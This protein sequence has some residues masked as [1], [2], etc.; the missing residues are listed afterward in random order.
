MC[1]YL[2]ECLGEYHSIANLGMDQNSKLK[3]RFPLNS[4]CYF[5]Q[6]EIV[7]SKVS[8]IIK[9][10]AIAHCGPWVPKGTHFQYPFMDLTICAF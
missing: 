8:P 6:C 7:A 10:H 5:H 2:K 9:V 3:V 4:A 1:D